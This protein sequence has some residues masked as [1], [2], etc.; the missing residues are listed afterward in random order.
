V[1]TKHL[2]ALQEYALAHEFIINATGVEGISLNMI[3]KAKA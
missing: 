1:P 2:I 3:A